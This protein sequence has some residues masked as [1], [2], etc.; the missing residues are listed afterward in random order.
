MK[1]YKI[2]THDYRPPIQLGAPIWDGQVGAILP[3]TDL[4]RSDNVCGRGWNFCPSLATAFRIAGLWPNGWPSIAL[5]VESMGDVVER[6]N[7][8]RSEQLLICGMC[9][10]DEIK[11]A[12][13]EL[14][15]VFAPHQNEMLEE[16]WA[17]RS[18]LA[19][20]DLDE[21][22]IE[23][24]LQLAL[25]ERGLAW[26]L[27]RYEDARTAWAARAVWAA[28][29]ARDAWAVWDA[30]A[31]RAAWD[32]WDAWDAWAARDA[33]AVWAAR[34]ARAAWDA[35]AAWDA[36]TVKYTSLQGWVKYPPD[37]LTIGLRDA[38][39][40]G[41]DLAIPTSSLELGWT[42]IEEVPDTLPV[43]LT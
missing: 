21:T 29:D 36:L 27:K 15:S 30:R 23:A 5:Q 4:D 28:R 43:V 8:C 22:L 10:E 34:D 12:I 11:A 32:A 24:N 17:W 7:K 33:R 14:S 25:K 9:S 6:E 3:K 39:R 2:L 13:A 35:W 42:P 19:R 1:G 20:D 38:Y 26:S 18:A 40:H 31:A 41:L 16:Q 37:L